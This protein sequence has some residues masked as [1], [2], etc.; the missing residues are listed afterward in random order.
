MWTSLAEATEVLTLCSKYRTDS[1]SF[2]IETK[3]KQQTVLSQEMTEDSK[4]LFWG[5]SSL[6]LWDEVTI[7]RVGMWAPSLGL[8]ALGA[9]ELVHVVVKTNYLVGPPFVV[10][11]SG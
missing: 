8:G 3:M 7:C 9:Q 10:G 1:D 5:H 6:L 2:L 11:L 4:G